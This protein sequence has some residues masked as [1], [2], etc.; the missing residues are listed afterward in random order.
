MKIIVETKR[1]SKPLVVVKAKY[2]NDY[3]MRI[4]FSDG[5]ERAVD[6][7]PFLSGSNHPEIR[8]YLKESNFKRYKIV[9]GNLNWDD[10]SLIFPIEDL[11]KGQIGNNN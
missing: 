7:K 2:L 4:N 5:K 11:Y 10:Y 1:Q 3:V 9:G 8:K 6:F